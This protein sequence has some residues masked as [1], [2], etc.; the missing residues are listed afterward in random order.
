VRTSNRW[1]LGSIVFSL[2]G[3]GASVMGGRE[4]KREEEATW[5]LAREQTYL[6]GVE[7]GKADGSATDS[8]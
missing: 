6:D 4:E 8:K 2:A 5:K 7:K 1:Y 3:I